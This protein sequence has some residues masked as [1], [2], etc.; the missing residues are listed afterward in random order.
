MPVQDMRA[1][2]PS[3]AS[4]QD[5]EAF[6]IYLQDIGKYPLLTVQQERELAIKIQAGDTKARESMI[7]SNLR[8][9]VRIAHDYS[10]YG[11]PLL[12]L[13]S[14]GNIGLMKAAERF[15][16]TK[17]VKF[18][19]Y[20]AWW[21]KQCIKRALANQG[22]TIRLPIHLTE[23]MTRIRKATDELRKKLERD[24][25]NEEIAKATGLPT[26]KVVH[27]KLMRLPT[28]SFEARV[29]KDQH[30]LG[31]L[32]ADENASTPLDSLIQRNLKKELK[33]RLLKLTERER[34]IL[35]MR[36]GLDEEQPLTLE[37]VGRELGITR[38]RVRQIEG[39]ALLK[40]RGAIEA[41]G[42]SK[43]SDELAQERRERS[44]AEVIKEFLNKVAKPAVDKTAK[45]G[46]KLAGR[47]K[48]P[49]TP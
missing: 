10:Y 29:G 15:D 46:R 21:I 48:A 35:R 25:T 30:E 41:A 49:G 5:R 2:V 17:D 14:E 40:L 32:I 34:E 26:T 20:A 42:A 1:E 44:R 28:A 4:P 27:L 38:E 13:I 22:K 18:A 9:V 24:P 6:G 39:E 47:R 11:V 43:T 16:H 33:T 3:S 23:K 31:S 45:P 19:T 8:L 12:D 37:E 7:Q 36:F